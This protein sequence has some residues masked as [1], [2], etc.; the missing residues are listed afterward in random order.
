MLQVDGTFREAVS[1]RDYVFSLYFNV[2]TTNIAESKI[3]PKPEMEVHRAAE[4]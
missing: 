4:V 1:K 2:V 3:Y